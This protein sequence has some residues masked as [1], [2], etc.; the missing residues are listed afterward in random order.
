MGNFL[1]QTEYNGLR[2]RSVSESGTMKTV[3]VTTHRRVE[4]ETILFTYQME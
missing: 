1:A 3:R 4:E 2:G